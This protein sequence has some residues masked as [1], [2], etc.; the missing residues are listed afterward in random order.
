MEE[1]RWQALA[2]FEAG[3]DAGL[4]QY[5]QHEAEVKAAVAELEDVT[6]AG[7]A[8]PQASSAVRPEAGRGRRRTAPAVGR[9]DRG[10]PGRRQGD[11]RATRPPRRALL[12]KFLAPSTFVWPFLLLA[13]GLSYPLAVVLSWAGAWARGSRSG[14]PSPPR[15]GRTSRLRSGAGTGLQAQA[16]VLGLIAEANRL[17]A[18]KPKMGQDRPRGPESS[19]R[20]ATGRG[21]R[22]PRRPPRR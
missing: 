2:V 15:L 5:A 11:R 21:H 17:I 6:V 8:G 9:P 22:R 12:P 16:P 18:G 3:K 1:S 14:W 10:A 7:R 20:R 19:R 4:K 13:G